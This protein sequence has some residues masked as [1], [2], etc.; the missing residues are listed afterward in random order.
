LFI[1][2]GFKLNNNQLLFNHQAIPMSIS[3]NDIISDNF[4]VVGTPYSIEVQYKDDEVQHTIVA[5][6][7]QD[8]RKSLENQTTVP[9]NNQFKI[10]ES[11]NVGG[12]VTSDKA[13][14]A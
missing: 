14:I 12:P 8:I 9:Y 13:I 3:T 10:V 11:V 2:E 4:V 5:Y 7:L 6:Y 1:L